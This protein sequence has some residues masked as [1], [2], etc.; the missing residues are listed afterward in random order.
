MKHVMD[1]AL[2]DMKKVS[3]N[4]ESGLEKLKELERW[5]KGNM[6]VGKNQFA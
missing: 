6:S 1:E 2:D 3:K 4:A 5:L